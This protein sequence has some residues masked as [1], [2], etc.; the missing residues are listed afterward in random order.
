MDWM[1]SESLGV[2][3]CTYSCGQRQVVGVWTRK[4]QVV[5]TDKYCAVFCDVLDMGRGGGDVLCRLGWT[6]GEEV[7]LYVVVDRGRGCVV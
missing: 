7:L 6:W 1:R 5:T 2:T 4:Q 3:R